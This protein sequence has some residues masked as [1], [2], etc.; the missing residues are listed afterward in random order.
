MW[1]C[2]LEAGGRPPPPARSP[3]PYPP[4]YPPRYPP[5]PMPKLKVLIVDDSALIRSVMREV[6][7]GLPDL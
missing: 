3:L 5:T 6:I 4:R 7:N 1:S 2:S